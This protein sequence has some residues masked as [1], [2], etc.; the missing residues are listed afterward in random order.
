MEGPTGDGAIRR[1]RARQ[2][3][4]FLAVTLLSVGTPMLLMGDELGRTQDG[5]NNGYCLDGENAWLDWTQLAGLASGLHRFVRGLIALRRGRGGAPS[6]IEW[7]GV[8]LA[9]PDWSVSSHSLAVTMRFSS[10]A[11][12]LHWLLNAYWQPLSFELPALPAG[13][14]PWR[15]AVDTSRDSP[16]DMCLGAE[17]SQVSAAAIIVEPRSCIVLLSDA[18]FAAGA[19]APSAGTSAQSATASPAGDSAGAGPASMALM[20]LR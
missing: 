16:E 18:P 8:R 6:R 7:H 3:K 15:R 17:A 13:F 5:N 12:I 11:L 20:A 19:M 9:A 1:L 2:V 14:G 4:N 10:K